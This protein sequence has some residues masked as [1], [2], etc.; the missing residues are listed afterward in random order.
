MMDKLA[1][2]LEIIE[3]DSDVVRFKEL[4]RV[5]D[6]NKNIQR[7]YKKLLDAQ[8]RVVQT[9]QRHDE[10]AVIAQKNYEAMYSELVSYPP[11]QEYLDLID[12]LNTDLSLIQ[13]IIEQELSLDFD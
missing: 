12:L 2:L 6:Q 5:I 9:E 1:K 10:N 7:T 11:M 4:E 13:Q 8:K 3:N